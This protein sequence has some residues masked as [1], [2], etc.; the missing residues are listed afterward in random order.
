MSN[1]PIVKAAFTLCKGHKSDIPKSKLLQ[2]LEEIYKGFGSV[3]C[4]NVQ[5]GLYISTYIAHNVPSA[6]A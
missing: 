6:S 3:S 1:K 4:S 2:L 5:S